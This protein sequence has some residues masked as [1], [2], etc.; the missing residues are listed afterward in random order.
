MVTEDDFY[1]KYL[2]RFDKKS[3]YWKETVHEFKL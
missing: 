2:W 1:A 3:A